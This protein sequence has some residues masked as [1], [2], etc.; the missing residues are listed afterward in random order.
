MKG[1][2]KIDA[3]AICRRSIKEGTPPYCRSDK[4]PLSPQF[5]APKIQK[6]VSPKG[7]VDVEKFSEIFSGECFGGK[8]MPPTRRGSGALLIKRECEY[9]VFGCKGSGIILKCKR[10]AVL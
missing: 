8:E 2:D 4:C 3:V 6:K 9:D 7:L 1:R 5:S 10:I